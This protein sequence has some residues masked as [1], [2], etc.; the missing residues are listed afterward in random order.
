MTLSKIVLFLCVLAVQ[1]A[2]AKENYLEYHQKIIACERL[3][4]F[5]NNVP[6]ALAA[7]KEIFDDYKKPFAKDCFIALQL[8]C[9]SSDGQMVEYCLKKAFERGLEMEAMQ[10]SKTIVRYFSEHPDME[11]KATRLYNRGHA[12]FMRSINK[13]LRAEVIRMKTMDDSFKA[14]YNGQP[15][16]VYNRL[17]PEHGAVVDSNTL[18][19][20]RLIKKHGFLGDNV[21]GLMDYGFGSDPAVRRE[22]RYQVRSLV[23][24]LFFHHGCAYF[25]L[26]EELV[27][28]LQTG[29]IHPSMY[30]MIYEWAHK[31]LKERRPELALCSPE[32]KTQS[33]YYNNCLVIKPWEQH[34]DTAAVNRYRAEIALA[35]LD[36][37]ARKQAYEKE[38]GLKL[39][40]GMFNFY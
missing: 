17:K 36:H 32:G 29:E 3:F 27:A 26:E 2:S 23:D 39:L 10:S 12:D 25:M 30:A 6:S 8:A 13:E 28:A 40:F 37:V 33:K 16:E 24:Q 35:P 18:N 9:N 11:A 15:R 22:H 14:R 38:T 31:D 5:E 7:Y 19:L 34:K 1:S 21:I 4:L 20:A